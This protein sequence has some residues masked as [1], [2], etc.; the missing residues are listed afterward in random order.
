MLRIHGKA[1]GRGEPHRARRHRANEQETA[2]K[3]ILITPAATLRGKPAT[4]AKAREARKGRLL[5]G[6]T[7]DQMPGVADG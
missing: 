3:R 7:W 1:S 2:L 6:R 5:D 4:G